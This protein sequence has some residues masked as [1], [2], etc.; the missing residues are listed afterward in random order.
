MVR[1]T[2]NGMIHVAN[3]ESQVLN[4]RKPVYLIPNP[5]NL[6]ENSEVCESGDIV[7]CWNCIDTGVTGLCHER[8]QRDLHRLREIPEA[9]CKVSM[10]TQSWD[11]S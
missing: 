8:H 6:S 7:V 3:N 10:P 2:E 1:I 9:V 11:G 4:K 5:T